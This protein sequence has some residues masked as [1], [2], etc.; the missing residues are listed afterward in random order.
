[1]CLL[2]NSR[3]NNLE[4]IILYWSKEDFHKWL[5]SSIMYAF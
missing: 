5:I 2:F 4:L 3:K 1:M